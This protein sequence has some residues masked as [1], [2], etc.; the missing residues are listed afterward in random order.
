MLTLSLPRWLTLMVKIDHVSERNQWLPASYIID[1]HLKARSCLLGRIK[2]QERI[3]RDR[4]RTGRAWNG[5]PHDITLPFTWDAQLQASRLG[6][7]IA[8]LRTGMVSSV[9]TESAAWKWAAFCYF[10]DVSVVF[11]NYPYIVCWIRTCRGWSMDG[12][13]H[14]TDN[15]CILHSHRVSAHCLY[16]YHQCWRW[17]E[18]YKQQA[19]K[20]CL[21]YWEFKTYN[22]DKSVWNCPPSGASL[23]QTLAR[24]RK[25]Q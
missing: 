18:R 11:S 2:D 5:T 12:N 7:I 14:P 13:A 3:G 22:G 1:I 25:T 20:K 8:D 24:R 21:K 6:T 9:M 23:A 15:G 10:I 16:H 17:R 4:R 19:P